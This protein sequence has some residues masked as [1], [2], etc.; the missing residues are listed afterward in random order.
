MYSK[1]HGK[2]VVVLIGLLDQ[3]IFQNF[4]NGN[5]VGQPYSLSSHHHCFIAL[6]Q[7]SASSTKSVLCNSSL[8][9][10]TFDMSGQ[11]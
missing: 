3:S 9:H 5:S 4:E 2:A 10:K 7:G 8:M 1:F 11:G 6:N